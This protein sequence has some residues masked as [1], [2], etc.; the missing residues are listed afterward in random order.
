MEMQQACLHR[1]GGAKAR[2]I[3]DNASGMI[4]VNVGVPVPREFFM[5]GGWK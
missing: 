5:S 3:I 2:Y 4:G 1:N